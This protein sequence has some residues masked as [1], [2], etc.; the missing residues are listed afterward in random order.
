MGA[1]LI[2]WGTG[3]IALGIIGEPE[4]AVITHIRREGGE[5]TD[6]KS[7]R[8]TY[9]ISYIFTLPNVK[10]I[11]GL[12]KQIGDGI[13]QKVDSTSTVHIRYLPSFPYFNSMKKDVGM[14]AGSLILIVVGGV[15][16]FLMAKP[17][18]VDKGYK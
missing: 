3:K 10:E 17:I 16:I 9:S 8:Y 13:Y 4:K 12:T 14:S 18:N 6:I 5:R 1:A 7:S 2:L 15:L 11:N